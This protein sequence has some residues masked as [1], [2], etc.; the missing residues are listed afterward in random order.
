M[1]LYFLVGGTITIFTLASIHYYNVAVKRF[2]DTP[3]EL[4]LVKEQLKEDI[5]VAQ[6]GRKVLM[7]KLCE[8]IDDWIDEFGLKPENKILLDNKDE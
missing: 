8:D 4:G 3:N 7:E 6:G 2:V 5:K 1:I